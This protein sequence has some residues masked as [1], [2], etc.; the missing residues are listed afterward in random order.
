MDSLYIRQKK[1]KIRK[2]K[3][4]IPHQCMNKEISKLYA[5]G[6]D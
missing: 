5:S 3:L 1:E 2:G 4:S 6:A